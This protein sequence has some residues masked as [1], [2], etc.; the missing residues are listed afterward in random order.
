MKIERFSWLLELRRLCGCGLKKKEDDIFVGLL[1]HLARGAHLELLFAF[2]I[3][4]P[5]PAAPPRYWN[6]GP[7]PSVS[8]AWATRWKR[9][10]FHNIESIDVESDKLACMR[11]KRNSRVADSTI[12]LR[13]ALC[14]RRSGSSGGRF[15]VDGGNLELCCSHIEARG[16]LGLAMAIDQV[17]QGLP[18]PLPTFYTAL[19]T[20]AW[21]MF[22][23][24]FAC[25]FNFLWLLLSISH[26]FLSLFVRFWDL[27]GKYLGCR[28]LSSTHVCIWMAR[29]C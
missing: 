12:L 3:P 25:L 18:A 5:R 15:P 6:Q 14:W 23:S 7:A 27:Y 19:L 16:L 17:S 1:W 28:I 2:A 13:L 21:K 29:C 11:M 9:P 10:L 26:S 4:S 8:Q 20:S 22:S 24:P